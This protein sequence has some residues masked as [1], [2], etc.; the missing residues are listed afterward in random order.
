MVWYWINLAKNRDQ[1]RTGVN[2]VT[3]F[4]L[5]KNAWKVKSTIGGFSRRAKLHVV[6]LK[7]KLNLG[8]LHPVARVISYDMGFNPSTQR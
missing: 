8:C 1:W 4:W 5:A 7:T 6:Q 3:N 2:K